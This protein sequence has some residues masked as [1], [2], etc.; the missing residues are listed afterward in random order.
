[1][2]LWIL[3]QLL[4]RPLHKKQNLALSQ[5][6]QWLLKYSF[7]IFAADIMPRKSA[8]NRCSKD[9]VFIF[10]REIAYP[11]NHLYPLRASQV[12]SVLIPRLF[13]SFTHLYINPNFLLHAPIRSTHHHPCVRST[14]AVLP[15]DSNHSTTISSSTLYFQSPSDTLYPPAS[16]PPRNSPASK[17]CAPQQL[18]WSAQKAPKS[19]CRKQ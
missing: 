5:H 17:L 3:R 18:L 11:P 14:N 7:N 9:S 10:S 16:N 4:H 1:M 6:L 12:P 15:Y 19:E 2:K 13:S 8:Q